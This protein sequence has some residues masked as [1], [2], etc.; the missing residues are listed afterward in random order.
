MSNRLQ[1]GL[2]GLRGIE[3]HVCSVHPLM[4]LS[5]HSYSVAGL[6]RSEHRIFSC[7]RWGILS[8]AARELVDIVVVEHGL[9]DT[10]IGNQPFATGQPGSVLDGGHSG[11]VVIA[12]LPLIPDGG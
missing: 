8:L 4:A 12:T 6:A 7:I 5:R 3:G 1:L 11:A 9:R 2:S 10:V